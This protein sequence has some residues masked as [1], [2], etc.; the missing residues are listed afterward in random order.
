MQVH[1]VL[2]ISVQSNKTT[3]R[4]EEYI[5]IWSSYCERAAVKLL[6]PRSILRGEKSMTKSL[7]CMM[8]I[9]EQFLYDLK[10]H[11]T[12]CLPFSHYGML[13]AK[14]CFFCFLLLDPFSAQG[15]HPF[16]QPNWLVHGWH[17]MGMVTDFSL[18]KGVGKNSGWGLVRVGEAKSPVLPLH[19]KSWELEFLELLV[20]PS[21]T[22][23]KEEASLFF[24]INQGFCCLFF[25]V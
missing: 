4:I 3:P 13:E 1:E 21:T 8:R 17:S 11:F 14:N 2:Y 16:P 12:L 22:L 5:G 9:T 7:I 6:L 15:Q 10:P 25:L 23:C 20:R 18:L 19:W 24:M